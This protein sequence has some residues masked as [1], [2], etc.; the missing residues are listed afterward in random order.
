[1]INNLRAEAQEERQ[2]LSEQ[3]AYE[4]RMSS[5]YESCYEN[6]SVYAKTFDRKCCEMFGE[7]NKTRA[8]ASDHI[9]IIEARHN[10][11]MAEQ[12]RPSAA[13]VKDLQE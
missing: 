12:A 3:F 11:R 2:N 8:Q 4:R 6:E 5:G 7:D 1:M 9:D 10:E 13:V